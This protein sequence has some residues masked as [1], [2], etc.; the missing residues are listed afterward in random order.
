MQ[1]K[2]DLQEVEINEQIIVID[3]L[4]NEIQR[5]KD[6]N[7]QSSPPPSV[8]KSENI[9]QIQELD[10]KVYELESERTCLLFEHERL[11]TEYNLCL[12]E[13]QHLVQ[14]KNQLSNELKKTKLRIL[15][16]QDQV[17]KLKRESNEKKSNNTSST[18]TINRRVIKKKSKKFTMSKSCLELLLDQNSTLI[19]EQLNQSLMSNR[20]PRR[21]RHRSCSLCNHQ[22]DKPLPRK[23]CL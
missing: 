9:K 6:E 19:D 12:D 1:E 18:S 7:D 17:Y 14:Q 21:R 11:K 22:K 15:S 5:L 3:E 20:P 13:K 23:R 4:R 16:L 8:I 10:R 2:L